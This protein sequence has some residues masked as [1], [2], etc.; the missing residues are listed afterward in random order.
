M[1]N[2]PNP[3]PSE[4]PASDIHFRQA[5]INVILA[6]GYPDEA[7]PDCPC[8]YCVGY[9]I[10]RYLGHQERDIEQKREDALSAGASSLT[11]EYPAGNL[12][13]ATKG[14]HDAF[15]QLAETLVEHGARMTPTTAQAAPPKPWPACRRS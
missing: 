2:Q 11:Q 12:L 3:D 1:P 4:P 13:I 8:P 9:K 15:C 14:N 7:K 6:K 10:G 5:T